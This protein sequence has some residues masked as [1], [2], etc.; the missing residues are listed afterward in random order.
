MWGIEQHEVVNEKTRVN[1]NKLNSVHKSIPEHKRVIN[2]YVCQAD[3]SREI[4][5]RPQR[6]ATFRC[7]STN[8]ELHNKVIFFDQ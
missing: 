6:K 7:F 3:E 5:L 1:W 4:I 8:R 2:N